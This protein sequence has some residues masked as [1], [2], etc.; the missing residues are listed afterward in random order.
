VT[1]RDI[2]GNVNIKNRQLEQLLAES[3][4]REKEG[5]EKIEEER[6]RNEL[7]YNEMET[8]RKNK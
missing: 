8:M 6:R 3:E 5:R 1:V 2:L 4:R 7:M